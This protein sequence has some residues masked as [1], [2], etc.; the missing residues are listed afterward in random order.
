MSWLSEFERE[1]QNI[2]SGE[3]RPLYFCYGADSYLRDQAI[4]EIRKALK[5]SGA[6]YAYSIVNGSDSDATEIRDLLFGASLFQSQRCTVLF[7][8]KGLL[9]SARKVL[10][11]YLENPEPGNILILTA[12]TPDYKNS[13]YKRIQEHAFT[14]MTSAPFENE[15]PG[16]VRSYLA[17]R[18][19][20][21]SAAGIAELLRLV[22]ADL[23]NLSNELE[24]LDIYLPEGRK[25]EEEDVRMISGQSLVH[26]MDDLMAAIGRK[27]KARA[28]AVCKNLIENDTSAVYLLVALY[29]FIWKLIMLKD[30][31]MLSQTKDLA[32]SIRVF[33]KKQVEELQYYSLRYTMPELRR[34]L[35]ALVDADRRLKTSSCDNLSNLL[36]VLDGIMA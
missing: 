30:K 12:E 29:Q 27:D 7:E 11:Q 34:A 20:Q 36:I 17:D 9:P 23:G 22:G 35:S 2:R 4:S 21:I 3:L 13:L 5:A 33:R 1:I 24:K 25:V 6:S 15:I 18:G 8:V 31:R 28:F 32:K 26:S 14:L 16:W 10:L 19:R